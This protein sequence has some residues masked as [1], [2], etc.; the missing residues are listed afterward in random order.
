MTKQNMAEASNAA[1]P[2][3]GPDRSTYTMLAPA[4]YPTFNSIV[5]NPSIGDE[6]SF[7]RVGKV[8]PSKTVLGSKAELGLG[9]R[10]LVYIY[11]HN[12]ASATFND[13]EHDRAGIAHN[14]R[15]SASFPEKIGD[16]AAGRISAIVSAENSDPP[17]VWSGAVI[18]TTAK[19]LDLRY[20]EGSAKIQN[21]WGTNGTALPDAIFSKEGV[22]IGLDEL[23]GI[24]PGCEE[25]HCVVTFV[26][27]AV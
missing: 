25:Y 14:V 17:S 12:D 23:D 19:E 3:W 10:C 11:V 1:S 27:E 7:V 16:G 2:S 26:L 9:D 24:I 18:T 5:D 20:I 6:R 21:D 22:L 13:D 8:N 15:V 4:T